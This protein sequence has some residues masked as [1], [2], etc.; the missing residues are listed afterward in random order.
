MAEAGLL[1]WLRPRPSGE[2]ARMKDPSPSPTPVPLSAFAGFRF[3]PDVIV[4]AMRWYLRFCLSYRD[5]EELLLVWARMEWNM[6]V[7]RM[8]ARLFDGGYGGGRRR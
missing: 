2:T 8:V 7:T 1:R 4:L 6:G 3:P 5:V